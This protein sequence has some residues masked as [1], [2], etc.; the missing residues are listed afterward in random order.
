MGRNALGNAGAG[1]ER[2]AGRAGV[3]RAGAQRRTQITAYGLYAVEL[4]TICQQ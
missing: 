3:E 4:M 2:I 1:K